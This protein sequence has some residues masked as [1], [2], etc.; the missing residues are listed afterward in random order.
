L[1]FPLVLKEI[2][3]E[4]AISHNFLT[5]ASSPEKPGQDAGRQRKVKFEIA[6][7]VGNIARQTAQPA[8]AASRPKPP[9]RQGDDQT[10]DKKKLSDI[11]HDSI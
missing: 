11:L 2:H 6:A 10:D 4:N 5:L 1:V 7:L 9:A 8:Q 3:G